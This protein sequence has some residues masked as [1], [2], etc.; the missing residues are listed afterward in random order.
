MV[1]CHLGNIKKLEAKK[2]KWEQANCLVQIEFGFWDRVSSFTFPLELTFIHLHSSLGI[3]QLE[4]TP[5]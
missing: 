1:D 2:I 3:F 4:A 5:P